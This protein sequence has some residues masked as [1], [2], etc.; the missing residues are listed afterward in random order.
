MLM[1]LRA[2]ILVASLSGCLTL[3]M[4]AP[5]AAGD[6]LDRV[7]SAEA[8][9]VAIV[10][11]A[12]RS[13]VCIFDPSGTSG[14]S[15]VVVAPDGEGLT[16]YHVVAHLLE[17]RRGTAGLPDGR[18]YPLE[19]LGIDPTGDVAMFRL[20]GRDS[21]DA[22]PLGDSDAVRVGDP[23]FAAGNPFMLAE[24]FTPSVTA[25]IVSGLGR[26]QA[27][28][29]ARK[30][31][32]TDCIQVDASIN[33][34]NSG[35]P[36]FDA[37]GRLIGINGRASFE[38]RGRVNVGLAYAISINQIE[39]FM[40][41]LR[42]GLLVEH[43][44]LGATVTDAGF[45]RAVFDKVQGGSAA[46]RAG[47]RPGDR[48]A[49][50]DGRVIDSANQFLNV[51]GTY[52]AGWPVQVAWE[53]ENQK[54][55]K[56]VHLDR[57]PAVLPPGIGRSFK[58]DESVTRRAGEAAS[59]PTS[60]RAAPAGELIAAVDRTLACTVQLYGAAV[61]TEAGYGTGVI[62]S[63]QGHVMTAL[64]LLVEARRLRAVT[65]DGHV[66]RCELVY[67]DDR[68]Q[69]ALLKM[70]GR[71][72]NPDTLA[73]LSDQMAPARWESLAPADGSAAQL[74]DP[75]L[76]MGNPFK[77]AQGAE[78]LTVL[79]GA[80][81]GR[82]RL[83]A[84]KGVQPVVYRGEVLLLDAVTSNPGSPGSPVVDLAGRWVGLVGEMVT[85][86]LTNTHLNY[87]Y[88]AGEVRGFL[89]EALQGAGPAT[90]PVREPVASGPGYHGIRLSKIAYRRELPFVRS[91]A[92]G[93]PAAKA[94]VK[95]DDLI[96]SANGVAVT[97]AR[98]FE[99]LCERL[100]PGDELALTVKRGEVLVPIRFTLTEPAK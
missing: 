83:D 73:P 84:M 94:G 75:V 70:A 74:G 14:G 3:C 49:A 47:I 43:G 21:F 54:F 58:T 46:E 77:V 96:I 42:R 5:A 51:L 32:Y 59:Q 68:R 71:P 98:V 55:S 27:G 39:R 90:R 53:H 95:A 2:R 93:S 33:P 30:L 69:L 37:A 45:R 86:R 25:G 79:K 80:V 19:V 35:G 20:S 61:G 44:T 18:K 76:V 7:K 41:G 60:D 92:P 66:W 11:R 17:T 36:L 65:R 28:A 100:H 78:P 15:G 88:P 6:A 13:V 87:A 91:V 24:D 85:S 81:A 34:G 64:S 29:E 89:E 16:N 40:P 67:S 26:Y 4:A 99:E 57:L 56:V 12:G 38:R 52:P 9:R 63:P 31:V 82:C 48:L 62:V 22:A 23:V 97:Q 10:A 8:D 50:F 72:E 1:I